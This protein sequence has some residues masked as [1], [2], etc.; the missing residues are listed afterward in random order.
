MVDKTK[1]AAVAGVAGGDLRTFGPRLDHEL[2]PNDRAVMQGRDEIHDG[3]VVGML[4]SVS[5]GSMEREGLSKSMC[6]IKT[7]L[8]NDT[9]DRRDV[10]RK[11]RSDRRA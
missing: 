9:G 3:W 7:I 11:P 4:K 8:A 5:P 2:G 10:V 1:L 6:A